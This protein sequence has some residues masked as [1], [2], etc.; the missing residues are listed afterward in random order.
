MVQ[1]IELGGSDWQDLLDYDQ[2]QRQLTTGEALHG[3]RCE[4]NVWV[5]GDLLLLLK[6]FVADDREHE[7]KFPPTF[8]Y[9]SGSDRLDSSP[10]RRAP[11]WTDRIL[12]KNRFPSKPCLHISSYD[13]AMHVRHGDHRPV[14]ARFAVR[15]D[16][17]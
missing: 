16:L 17:P 4:W 1:L 2:L 15:N 9:D 6:M 11:A 10:K 7:I 5:V 3:F 8:K 12:Y 14:H 13:A